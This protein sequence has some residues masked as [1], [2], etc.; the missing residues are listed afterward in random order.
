MEEHGI[1]LAMPQRAN[2]DSETRF[3]A[4]RQPERRGRPRGSRNKMSAAFKRTMLEVM[5]ELGGVA[6]EDW[7]KLL[8][9]DVDDFK[10]YLKFLAIRHPKV[11]G[12]LL[13]RMIPP[14]PRARRGRRPM[15]E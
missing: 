9:G 7:D 2:V 5:Q 10:G 11:F 12:A 14:P 6:R 15:Q 4:D 8:T 1:R 3:S 13:C